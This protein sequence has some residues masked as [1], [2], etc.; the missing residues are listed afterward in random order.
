MVS[1]YGSLSKG[2]ELAMSGKTPKKHLD[3]NEE[4][5]LIKK[6]PRDILKSSNEAIRQYR[7]D[8]VKYNAL[9]QI[10]KKWMDW[11]QTLSKNSLAIF[12]L[13]SNHTKGT[14]VHLL[15]KAK[16]Q[17][18]GNISSQLVKVRK[19][20]DRVIFIKDYISEETYDKVLNEI[21]QHFFNKGQHNQSLFWNHFRYFDLNIFDQLNEYEK[22]RNELPE[23]KE[24]KD[25]KK[26]T[27]GMLFDILKSYEEVIEVYNSL[28]ATKKQKI[29]NDERGR[30][31]VG[32]KVNR[33]MKSSN[34]NRMINKYFGI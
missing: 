24:I 30:K 33:F 10:Q 9:K 27:L 19:L 8:K 23:S 26:T 34:K 28:M 12:N 6:L 4:K 32:K 22:L 29:T 1:K 7:D 15:E 18:R 5:I 3:F 21:D 17:P 25:F 20:Y 31:L 2:I 16:E 14:L 13:V 11:A